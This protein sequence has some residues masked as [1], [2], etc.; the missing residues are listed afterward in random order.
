MYTANSALLIARSQVGNHEGQ[1]NG[2]WNNRQKYSEQLPGFA[3]SDGQPWCATFVQWCLWQAG[4]SVPEGARSA[5]C[6]QSVAAYKK[7]HRFTEYPGI[8]FQVF[9]GANG[10]THTG[11]VY[12]YDSTYIYTIEGNTNNDGSAEG[13]GVYTKKRLRKVDFVYGYGIPYYHGKAETADKSWD[14]KDLS[15]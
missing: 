6:A 8:G 15:K 9:Y 10:G 14:G 4:V 12:D 3:W 1:T 13:D 11:I 2:H 7:A 5:G